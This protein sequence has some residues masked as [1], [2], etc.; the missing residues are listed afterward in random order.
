MDGDVIVSAIESIKGIQLLTC[1]MNSNAFY[2]QKN[3]FSFCMLK[4]LRF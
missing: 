3:V 4:I 1:P 2:L